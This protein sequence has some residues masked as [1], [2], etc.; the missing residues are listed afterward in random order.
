VDG[1]T[2]L[3]MRLDK[4]SLRARACPAISSVAVEVIRARGDVFKFRGR[5]RSREGS[6]PRAEFA[7]MGWW[8]P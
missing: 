1:K 2:I 4:L 8:L 6:P 7:A 3:F 5:A